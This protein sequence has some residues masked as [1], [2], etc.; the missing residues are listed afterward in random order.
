MSTIV[1]VIDSGNSKDSNGKSSSSPG[2][3]ELALSRHAIL[4]QP[5][6]CGLHMH[7]LQLLSPV[8]LPLH[9]TSTVSPPAN[10]H[11]VSNGLDPSDMLLSFSD[12]STFI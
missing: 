3:S 11:D 7:K 10:R 9:P 4:V 2:E 8:S 5:N 1:S 12:G 6:P